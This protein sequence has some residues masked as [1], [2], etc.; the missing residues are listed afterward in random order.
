MPPPLSR[1]PHRHRAGRLATNTF[2]EHSRDWPEPHRQR[3]IRPFP[4]ALHLAGRS[5]RTWHCSRS[6]RRSPRRRS[7]CAR[8]L[9]WT[10]DRRRSRSGVS[11]GHPIAATTRPHG[12]LG[13]LRSRRR[14]RRY[15]RAVDVRSS[16]MGAAMVVEVAWNGALIAE[17]LLQVDSDRTVLLR[18]AGVHRVGC[19]TPAS[20]PKLSDGER[21]SRRTSSRSSVLAGTLTY[22][23]S[24]HHRSVQGRSGP[25][26]SGLCGGL[27]ELSEGILVESLIVE[28]NRGRLGVGRPSCRPPPRWRPTAASRY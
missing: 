2:V 14:G 7:A 5:S 27:V 28:A 25:D 12:H 11:L 15:R 9:G 16:S 24:S 17:G 1:S 3:T 18:R 10:G 21:I 8:E 26:Y 20:S 4:K 19:K 22:A 6:M 23:A 13:D